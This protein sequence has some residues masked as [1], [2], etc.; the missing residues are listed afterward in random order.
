[1]KTN[2][3]I[4]NA[5]LIHEDLRKIGNL[6]PVVYPVSQKI[7]YDFLH[8]QYR[9]HCDKITVICYESAQMVHEKL[10]HGYGKTEILDLK[11]LK[12]LAH[13]VYYGLDDSMDSV[14]VN[15]SDTIVSDNI[16]EY[17]DDCYFY[18]EEYPSEKW[19]FFEE[20]DGRIRKI[21]DKT[22]KNNH[23]EIQKLF[24]GVFYFH[25]AALLKQCFESAFTDEN[26]EISAF[27]RAV[28]EYSIHRPLTPIKT[29]HWFDIGHIEKYYNASLEVKARTFNHITIDKNRG[30]LKKTSDDKEKFIGEVLWYLKLPADIE[31]VRPRIFSYSVNHDS[32]YVEMEY[33]SYH[34]LH[35]L[36]LYGELSY[37]QW[38]DAFKR[39]RFMC[40]DFRRYRLKDE[41]ILDALKDMYLDKT[42]LRL[43]KIRNSKEFGCFFKNPITINTV[44]YQSLDN[45]SETLKTLIPQMLYDVEEFNIIH[46]D[47]CFANI[48]IDSNFSFIKVIDPRGKFGQY[49]IYGDFRYELAKLFHSVDGKYDY[50]IKDKFTIHVDPEQAVIDYAITESSRKQDVFEIF[51]SVFYK[52]IGNDLNKIYLIEALLFLSMIPLHTESREHQ[53][54]MLA[55]GIEILSRITDIKVE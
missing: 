21:Y 1:M 3:I 50:I 24:V 39:I 13:T 52:D 8:K 2:V 47:L 45:I 48:M 42:L 38:L 17:N 22:D 6:T 32:P 19:T 55:T 49:D 44:R 5:I 15:F 10:M 4:P 37:N 11:E 40:N 54:A 12:D 23:Q 33:Y 30:I 36:Y 20:E 43:E 46:G 34:T 29:D 41:H 51:L 14:I 16:Y 53:Y 31:Y 18:A 7:V 9:D 35:E 25:D 27:Y 28:M 26:S